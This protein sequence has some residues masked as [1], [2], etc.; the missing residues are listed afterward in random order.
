MNWHDGWAATT[1]REAWVDWF[2]SLTW[3][4][5]NDLMTWKTADTLFSMGINI[6]ASWAGIL[7]YFKKSLTA[8]ASRFII[9]GHMLFFCSHQL[10]EG[11]E[12]VAEQISRD[13]SQL[14]SQLA[15]LW[16]SFLEAAVL[17]PHILSY[18]A[19]EHHTLRVR[20]THRQRHHPS[21]DVFS[22]PQS[23]S[24]CT[25]DNWFKISTFHLSFPT[26]KYTNRKQST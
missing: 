9:Y 18:L 3:A 16:S 14:C 12:K 7:K 4:V 2:T 26:W 8:N 13:V 1:Q 17:N 15:A 5:C 6:I 19:Q 21:L 10:Q 24:H 25:D 22:E 11:H 20:I 23:A